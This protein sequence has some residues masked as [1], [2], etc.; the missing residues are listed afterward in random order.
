MEDQWICEL[1]GKSIAEAKM[2]LS[3]EWG[4]E[5]EIIP[6]SDA[7]WR[8]LS[9]ASSNALKSS[10]WPSY[11]NLLWAKGEQ[12][13]REG[14]IESARPLVCEY[15]YLSFSHPSAENDF[16]DSIELRKIGTPQV[17]SCLDRS[18]G[19]GH[20]L[21]TY[22]GMEKDFRRRYN[23]QTSPATALRKFLGEREEDIAWRIGRLNHE[24]PATSESRYLQKLI[25]VKILAKLNEDKGSM[26]HAISVECISCGSTMMRVDEDDENS[27]VICTECK[28]PWCTM[29]QLKVVGEYVILLAAS[30]SQ[31]GQL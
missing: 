11:A 12:L 6:E 9:L 27:M 18:G 28:V 21:D 19:L 25:G 14:K 8:L 10:D 4:I 31:R 5:L 2:D 26:D 24:K 17:V 22:Q 29:R 20:I 16:F 13:Y 15:I 1:A 30:K 3:S 23:F 7:R